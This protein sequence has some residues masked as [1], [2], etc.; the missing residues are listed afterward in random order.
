MKL[1]R[2][3]LRLTRLP[4]VRPF[5]TSS[6][7]KSYIEH[8]LV[9]VETD[10]GHSGW[11]ECAS[12]SDP[13]YCPETVATC[14]HML[15]D[16]LTP[17][18]LGKEWSSLDDFVHLYRKVKGNNFAKAGLEMACW[19]AVA[20]SQGQPL[21]AMLGGTR[22]EIA[23]G[24]SLGIEKDLGVL[25]ALVE[26]YLAEGYRRI[27]LKVGPGHDVEV[28]SAVRAK[29]GAIPLQ[30]DANSA[31]TLADFD[32]LKALDSFDL[33]LIEQPLAHDD[34][35]DHARLQAQ[36]KTPICLDESI[37]S[38]EDARKALEIDAG[39]VI[40]I[41][42]SRVGGLREAKAI[43]DLCLAHKIPVWCG[44]MHE[45]GIG[46]AANVAIASLPGFSLPGDVSGSDKY[47]KTDLVEPTIVAK[48]GEITVPSGPGLGYE[49]ILERIDRVTSR[50]HDET[51]K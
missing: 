25:I 41:K 6:S 2:I 14:W 11:G 37:H 22:R 12:P 40:N 18:T 20:R 51:A 29:F 35:I 19:D 16:F 26:Q 39:R 9:R 32:I 10:S 49:P 42:V 48:C 8:I 47:Y 7:V 15:K 44:G 24:V 23:S 30:V 43:H 28:V 46:R 50:Y 1:H 33:L 38:A 17:L 21:A 31:Y 36:M 4:L 45:F 27:K 13:Y 34:M 5:R 3:E